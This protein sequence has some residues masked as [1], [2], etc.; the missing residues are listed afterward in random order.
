MLANKVVR[1][2]IGLDSYDN[3]FEQIVDLAVNINVN[4]QSGVVNKECIIFALFSQMFVLH[5]KASALFLA[6]RGNSV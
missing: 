1:I 6:C 2:K 5:A 4:W 3:F